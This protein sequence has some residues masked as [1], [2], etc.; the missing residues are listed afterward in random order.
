MSISGLLTGWQRS[1]SWYSQGWDKLSL[2]AYITGVEKSA[3]VSALKLAYTAAGG[4][5]LAGGVWRKIPQYASG[6]NPHGS[7]FIAGE[8]GAELVGHIGGRTE[9]LNRSQIA[10]S[11]SAGVAKAIAGIRFHIEGFNGF[12]PD[13]IPG[14]AK[15][16]VVPPQLIA[17]TASLDE[18]KEAISSLAARLNNGGGSRSYEFTAQ[19]NRRTLFDE[20][21]EEA[22]MRRTMTGENPF[23]LARG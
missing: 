18:I 6:G 20:M 5:V 19:I 2:T 23:S 21:I 12:T 15:G 14:V 11:V 4:G 8:A 22:Q 3:A 10:A 13:M 17:A 16:T 1:S 7:L 9:V